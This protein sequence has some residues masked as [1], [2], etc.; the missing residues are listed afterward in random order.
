MPDYTPVYL[1]GL[2]VTFQAAGNLTGGD[3]VE[4]AGSGTVQRVASAPSAKYVGIAAADVAAGLEVTVIVDKVI[5]EGAA[6]GVVTAG[7]ELVASAVAGRQVRSLPPLAAPPGLADVNAARSVI[8][9][10]LI[11]AGD[12]GTVRWMQK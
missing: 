3:P 2:T 1:P 8:G 4:V 10:A 6:D 9:L 7:D 12:G 11:T 5:H